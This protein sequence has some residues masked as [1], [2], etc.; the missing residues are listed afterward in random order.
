MFRSILFYKR[1]VTGNDIPLIPGGVIDEWFAEHEG[2]A[3]SE[4]TLKNIYMCEGENVTLTEQQILEDDGS[5]WYANRI[6]T[7]NE[8]L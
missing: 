6:G 1:R 8:K 3:V 2:R 5:I 4:F 7:S